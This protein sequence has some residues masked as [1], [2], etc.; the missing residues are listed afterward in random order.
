M[1]AIALGRSKNEIC[2]NPKGKCIHFGKM[3]CIH[4][5]KISGQKALP[6]EKRCKG[7]RVKCKLFI[8][9]NPFVPS[10]DGDY[11]F[12]EKETEALAMAFQHGD[13]ILLSGPPGCISGETPLGISRGNR[14]HPRIYSIE[15]A[16][17][18]FNHIPFNKSFRAKCGRKKANKFW[19]KNLPTK[20]LALEDDLAT[21]YNEIEEIIYSGIKTTYTVKVSSGK[22]IRVTKDHKFRV[23]KGT[24]GADSEGFK[25]LKDLKVKDQVIVRSHKGKGKGRIKRKETSDL[26]ILATFHPNA[27]TKIV[28]LK[29]PNGKLYKKYTYIHIQKSKAK[30]EARMN[31]LSLKEF[32]RIIAKDKKKAANLKYLPHEIQIHH[33]DR[34][35]ENNKISNLQPLTKSKHNKVHSKAEAKKHLPHMRVAIRK[36]TSIKK[37]GKEETFDIKMKGKYKNFTANDFIIHNSGKTSLAKQIA[38]ILNWGLIQFSCS[39]ETS[40]AKLLGEWVVIGK[41]MKW[42]DGLITTA[43]KYGHVL[44]EDEADFMRPEL[45]GELHSIME[46]NGSVTL[47]AIHPDTKMPFQKVINK[48]P[49]FRWVS[50]ANTI[51]LGDDLFQYHGTQYF[52]SAARDRYSVILQFKYKTP[53]EE[54]VILERKTGI[55][56]VTATEMIKIAN[57][58]REEENKEI[59]FQFTLRRLMAWAKY[60]TRMNAETASEI[61][62]L[63]FCTDTD[64]YFIKSLIRTHLNLEVE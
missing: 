17:H 30:I 53:E 28:R 22:E 15:E 56:R 49:M 35:P 41:D 12:S 47:S 11:V 27:W 45:R 7:R 38:S 8:G 57:A 40:S 19:D 16:Y 5:K 33:K 14:H 4:K 60:W 26:F 51:G 37:Y 46:E 61:S 54:L 20:I 9:K 42:S 13:N 21:G 31:S 44:L 34:N 10:F 6:A 43:M 25:R 32:S 63:N 2:S 50:T 39:E 3:H 59:N 62:I 29:H 18:K 1:T 52:N 24:K 23:P 55:E 36:I 64:R 48:H 58:C